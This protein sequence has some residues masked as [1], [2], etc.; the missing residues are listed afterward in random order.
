MARVHCLAGSGQ[1]GPGATEGPLPLPDAKLA[2]GV[3]ALCW[4][5]GR[6]WG[7]GWAGH[8]R[9]PER[10]RAVAVRQ[11]LG[12]RRKKQPLSSYRFLHSYY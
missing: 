1:P 12:R 7:G 9:G 6:V 4:G 11:G 3:T 5:S 8:W 2:V 10:G